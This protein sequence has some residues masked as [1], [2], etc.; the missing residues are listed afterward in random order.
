[1]LQSP[2][3][4]LRSDNLATT[5]ITCPADPAQNLSIKLPILT[6]VLRNLQQFVSVEVHVLDDKHVKRRFRASNFQV[7]YR[8]EVSNHR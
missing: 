7:P 6:F 8:N 2:V 5:S 3:L 1:M 4:S